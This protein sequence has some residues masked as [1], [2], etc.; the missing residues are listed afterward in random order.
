MNSSA[1]NIEQA[2]SQTHA[3]RH[4]PTNAE[5]EDAYQIFEVVLSNDMSF[6]FRELLASDLADLE[7]FEGTDFNKS[8]YTLARVLVS[9]NGSPRF[10]RGQ[11]LEQILKWP[12]QI[13]QEL[14]EKVT[15]KLMPD[16]N[17]IGEARGN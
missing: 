17:P 11:E 7:S 6:N 5:L 2:F 13:V 16:S 14:C 15:L 4:K 10:D 3:H 8:I 1:E 9:E 12:A